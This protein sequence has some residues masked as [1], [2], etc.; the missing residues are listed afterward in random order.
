MAF[1][2]T[3]AGALPVIDMTILELS[4]ELGSAVR[5]S[6]L[7]RVICGSFWVGFGYHMP[8]AHWDVHVG[9]WLLDDVGNEVVATEQRSPRLW[10][11]VVVE[12][13]TVR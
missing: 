8:V 2:G 6:D 4:K 5:G 12:M 13:G 10:R 1:E 3:D 9:G 7:L 11:F